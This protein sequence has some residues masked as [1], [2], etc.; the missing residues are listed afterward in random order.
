MEA[1]LPAGSLK[2]SGAAGSVPAATPHHP[3][4][5]PLDLG[6][7]GEA[8]KPTVRRRKVKPWQP[9]LLG[10]WLDSVSDHR[11]YPVFHLGAFAGV[12]RGELLGLT[13]DDVDLDREQLTV[14]WQIA[15]VSYGRARR[16]I[17]TGGVPQYLRPPKTRDG[18]QRTVD[19][20]PHTVEVLRRSRKAQAT[21]QLSFSGGVP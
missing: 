6:I 12:R 5:R 14:R 18:E 21:P 11:L 3:R 9:E 20:D 19:L 8:E 17:K 1:G 13:W 10:Q 2:S 16:A 15:I 7:H 4:R